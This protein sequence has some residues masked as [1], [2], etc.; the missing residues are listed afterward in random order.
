MKYIK[1]AIDT[2]NI[3]GFHDTL[4]ENIVKGDLQCVKN[5]SK[6]SFKYLRLNFGKGN[7]QNVMNG[8]K[9]PHW[10]AQGQIN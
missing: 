8:M 3:C 5:R 6:F 2:S 1:W 7:T 10:N 9:N 4:T